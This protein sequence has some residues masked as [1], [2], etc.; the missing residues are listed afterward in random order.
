MNNSSKRTVFE[1][2]FVSSTLD[3][4][5]FMYPSTRSTV[6]SA[7]DSFL[8]STVTLCPWQA[9]NKQTNVLSANARSLLL[10]DILFLD[11]ETLVR[12]DLGPTMFWRQTMAEQSWKTWP[13]WYLTP[14]NDHQVLF[15][16][17]HSFHHIIPK[18]STC[19]GSGILFST[20][21]IQ[22]WY[23][24]QWTLQKSYGLTVTLKA[25]WERLT[26]FW[27][28]KARVTAI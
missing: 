11:F 7:K 17:S 28:E 13:F 15:W 24:T 16:L 6:P 8:S 23:T 22:Y 3:I 5:T 12:G 27:Q 19:W 9:C 20:P 10:P 14:G 26:R 25:L 18:M 2:I 1:L 21:S 4:L